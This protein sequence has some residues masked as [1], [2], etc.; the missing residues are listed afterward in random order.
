M[1]GLRSLRLGHNRLSTL[2]ASLSLLTRLSLLHVSN[3]VL[4][5]LPEALSALHALVDLDLSNNRLT[6]L[7]A[8]LGCATG[9]TRLVAARNPLLAP[10]PEVLRQGAAAAVRYLA[11]VKA[12]RREEP[13]DWRELGLMTLDTLSVM[14][15]D[16]L[17]VSVRELY[18]D[19]NF[20]VILHPELF[21]CLPNL[22]V[23]CP[24][25]ERTPPPRLFN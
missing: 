11:G 9:L 13:M 6:I 4:A 16:G 1:P 22:E 10:P 15:P 8:G 17:G 23:G 19:D 3:N 7:P 21:Q 25:L 14:L 24:M 5:A 2:P 12:G 18:L 20:L